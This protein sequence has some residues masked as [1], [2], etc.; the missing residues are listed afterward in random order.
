MS[1][2]PIPDYPVNP[3]K[4]FRWYLL[5]AKNGDPLGQANIGELYYWGHGVERDTQKANKWWRLSADQGCAKAQRSLGYSYK[6]GEGVEEDIDAAMFW[7]RLAA[8]QGDP[9]ANLM[10]H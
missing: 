7:F 10:F 4:A 2:G 1:P 5:A 3:E 9:A 8:K 6:F